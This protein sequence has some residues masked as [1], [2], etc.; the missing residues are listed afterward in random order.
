MQQLELTDASRT[1]ALRVANKTET[2]LQ[3]VSEPAPA[4]SFKS[5]SPFGVLEVKTN[6]VQWRQSQQFPQLTLD[7]TRPVVAGEMQ[8]R[9]IDSS[10]FAMQNLESASLTTNYLLIVYHYT[11]YETKPTLWM[12]E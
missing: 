10:R 3:V 9:Q 8:S 12:S 6:K 2:V 4:V 11:L 7:G 1:S 5:V